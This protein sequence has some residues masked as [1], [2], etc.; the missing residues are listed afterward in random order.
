MSRSPGNLVKL[1][2]EPS[3]FRAGE[4]LQS[5]VG[6][7]AR[8]LHAAL[9][10]IFPTKAKARAVSRQW[11]EASIVNLEGVYVHSPDMIPML[12]CITPMDYWDWFRMPPVAKGERL[13]AWYNA[14][15]IPDQRCPPEHLPDSYVAARLQSIRRQSS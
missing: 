2:T 15:R 6:G 14:L 13:V 8:V 5:W 7:R 1:G 9:A 11:P 10:Q 4:Q 12:A 3:P